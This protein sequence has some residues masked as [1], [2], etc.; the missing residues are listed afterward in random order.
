MIQA[1]TVGAALIALFRD[2]HSYEDTLDRDELI[3]RLRAVDARVNWAALLDAA[4]TVD[5]PYWQ[6]PGY[7]SRHTS[8]HLAQDVVKAWEQV[9]TNAGID[10][11]FNRDFLFKHMK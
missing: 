3:R 2:E 6:K 11:M 7:V 4:E 8:P 10:N 9:V 1:K 5:V